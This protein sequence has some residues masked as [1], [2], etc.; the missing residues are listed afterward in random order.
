MIIVKDTSFY[1]YWY[2]REDGTPYYIGKG[3]GQRAFYGPHSVTIP[4]DPSRISLTY[5]PSEDKAFEMESFY[6]SQFGR[7]DL[8][9]GILR[10]LS[11]GGVGG[12][13][14]AIRS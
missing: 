2:L 14:G 8:G 7:K 12:S 11:D 6:I 13:S 4:S 3:K 1:T 5:W 9:T 10:N